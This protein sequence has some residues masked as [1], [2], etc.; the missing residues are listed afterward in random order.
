MAAWYA[1]VAVSLLPPFWP[2]ASINA[3]VVGGSL[4][5]VLATTLILPLGYWR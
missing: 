3:W 2:V 4:A 5:G 1:G